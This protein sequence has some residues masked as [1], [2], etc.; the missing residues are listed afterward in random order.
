VT[1][2][3]TS[4][5]WEYYQQLPSRIQE[6]ADRKFELLKDDP[7][8]PSLHFKKVMDELWS[9]HV[10]LSYRALGTDVNGTIVWFWIG[11]HAEYDQIL[12]R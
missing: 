1:H 10:G 11:S 7:S 5:F 4:E 2:R 12:S 9:V 6:K 8:H 3:A